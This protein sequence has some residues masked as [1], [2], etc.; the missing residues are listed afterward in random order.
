MN[1][2]DVDYSIIITIIIVISSAIIISRARPTMYELSSA[3]RPNLSVRM[4][5]H[6]KSETGTHKTFSKVN[7]ERRRDNAK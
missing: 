4:P 6:G 2:D 5:N 3:K 7:S 1:D